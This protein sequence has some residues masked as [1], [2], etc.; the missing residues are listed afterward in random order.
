MLVMR[1]DA[2]TAPP[3]QLPLPVPVENPLLPAAMEAFARAAS[4]LT[5]SPL[6]LA[7]RAADER[8][9]AASGA[10]VA[11][12]VSAG[13]SATSRPRLFARIGAELAR[14]RIACIPQARLVPAGQATDFHDGRF[15]VIGRLGTQ[16]DDLVHFMGGGHRAL[17]DGHHLA[18]LEGALTALWHRFCSPAALATSR[19]SLT[20]FVAGCCMPS[21]LVDRNLNL[22][23]SN[24]AG[25]ALLRNKTPLQVLDGVL[26][27]SRRDVSAAFARAAQDLATSGRQPPRL[28]NLAGETEDVEIAWLRP[29][30]AG[31]AGEIIVTVA[32][33]QARAHAARMADAFGLSLTKERIVQALLEG[34][35]EDEI[36]AMLKLTA[37]SVRTYIKRLMADIGLHRRSELHRLALDLRSPFDDTGRLQAG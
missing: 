1:R 14:E 5:D 23:F 30:R 34:R 21:F 37:G 35:S 11:A 20:A 25:D 18:A 13:V 10:S 26:G 31:H 32:R 6:F 29:A 16:G 27:P 24:A 7:F 8:S 36:A 17:M 22:L 28:F 33:P 4:T 9:W 15:A 3:W 2:P 19:A 12:G